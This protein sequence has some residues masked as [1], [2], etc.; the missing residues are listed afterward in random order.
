[1]ETEKENL[2]VEL[3]KANENYMNLTNKYT[4]LTDTL[5]ALKKSGVKGNQTSSVTSL[6]K[7]PI[8]SFSKVEDVKANCAS[9]VELGDEIEKKLN[10][11]LTTHH[12]RPSLFSKLEKGKYTCD[13]KIVLLKLLNDQLIIKAGDEYKSLYEFAK[14]K[15]YIRHLT[16]SASSLDKSK[17]M[18]RKS[19]DSKAKFE[20]SALQGNESC[21]DFSL[22]ARS[23]VKDSAR[24]S[25]SHSSCR[26]TVAS[27][28]HKSPL[29]TRPDLK[30]N[31]KLR[32]ILFSRNMERKF[33][34]QT[35]ATKA[36]M[37]F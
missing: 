34:S 23:T 26:K 3:F 22:T 10:D 11:F 4:E 27:H 21:V 1:L 2:R 24:S 29:K 15:N 13:G 8:S 18:E 36:K 30:E 33:S 32:E 25:I 28:Y 16:K 7:L 35:I 37:P 20:K 5:A 17:S 19:V 6:T 12:I 31:M 14:K 9:Q